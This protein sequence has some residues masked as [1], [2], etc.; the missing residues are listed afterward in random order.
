MRNKKCRILLRPSLSL[1]LAF[2]LVLASVPGVGVLAQTVEDASFDQMLEQLRGELFAPARGVRTPELPQ[3][4]VD[5]DGVVHTP[6]EEV[7]L[8]LEAEGEIVIAPLAEFAPFVQGSTRLFRYPNQM[9][10]LTRQGARV[11]V[12][13]MD[14][15]VA[16][17]VDDAM[18]QRFDEIV[19][20]MEASFAPFAG[21]RVYTIWSTLVPVVGDVHRDGR[22]NVLLHN[23]TGGGFFHSADYFWE[24]GVEP[25]ALFHVSSNSINGPNPDSLY[26]IFAHEL[27]HL[28]FHQHFSVY[29]M[30]P[31]AVVTSQ[32]FSWLNE[33]L[34]GL[35]SF[36]YTNPGF[37][38]IRVGNFWNAASNSY[39]NPNDD[40]IG[41]FVNF[42]NSWK[43]Y[44]MSDLYAIFLHHMVSS[45][46]RAIFDYFRNTFPPSSNGAE[47]MANH[48]RIQSY[49]MTTIVGN[50][51]HAAGL[52]GTTGASG[53]TAFNLLYFLF[54]EN[55]AADG[56][57]VVASSD[58][59]P[60]RQFINSPYSAH[61]L[62]GVRPNLGITI[63]NPSF[64]NNGVFGDSTTAAAW[65]LGARTPFNT[66][67]SG[68]TVS[69][70]GYNGTPPL[71]ATHERFYRLV[72]ESAA[73]PVL[74]ISIHDNDSRTQYYVVIPNDAPGAVSNVANRRLG[75][76]GATVHLLT[77]GGVENFIDTGG[78]TAY[79]FVVTLYR[80]V[81]AT[82]SYSWYS[83]DDAITAAFAAVL[84][85]FT[86]F[87]FATTPEASL[88]AQNA[89]AVAAAKFSRIYAILNP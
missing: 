73:N 11:N 61:N 69:M 33:G 53:T 60:T 62:W 24:N 39:E 65:N 79:L 49:G 29:M 54:M 41:D 10:T 31:G 7:V 3:I 34:S 19:T 45:Y 6:P 59:H 70:S 86:D 32:H 81:S 28:L 5:D 21:I 44:S 42:N 25:I 14:T 20:L 8:P 64:L 52:T 23:H 30:I 40:R 56:G 89:F 4:F 36:L 12:W 82:V 57:N 76:D 80:N 2:V 46:A 22:V 72:G 74:N 63:V 88:A 83:W 17:Q 51:L 47:F 71:G 43:N 35:A 77:R 15:A 37:E 68:G 9:G 87:M 16:S 67:S 13:T 18:V 48:N 58:V 50:A 85:A 84:T 1:F 78:Q 27:Q 55:F 26:R 75:M 66:L 38:T